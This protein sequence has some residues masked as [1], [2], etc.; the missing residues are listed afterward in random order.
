MALFV[1]PI[2]IFLLAVISLLAFETKK[3]LIAFF[4]FF[5]FI[6]PFLFLK[7]IRKLFTKKIRLDFYADHFSMAVFNIKTTSQEEMN[8]FKWDDIDAY[9]VTFPT[10]EYTTL[11]LY[12][13]GGNKLAMTMQGESDKSGKPE[14]NVISDKL[15]EIISSYNAAAS[16][17][18]PINFSPAFLATKGGIVFIVGLS[19]LFLIAIILHLL[20]NSKPLPI[21][22]ILGLGSFMQI[23]VKRKK[24][25]EM[26][27]KFGMK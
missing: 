1:V 14:K 24:D 12:F 9:G 7:R 4:G 21:T 15:Y 26:Y 10:I 6:I 23:L 20:Y 27:K 19:A 22:L 2:F 11:K 13:K 3:P 17:D 18:K 25:M 8:D 5:I 16:R